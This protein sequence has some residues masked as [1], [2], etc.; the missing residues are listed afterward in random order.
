MRQGRR[1]FQTPAGAP[2]ACW[3]AL[4]GAA[5]LGGCVTTTTES[6]NTPVAESPTNAATFNVQLGANYLRQGDLQLAK[7]KIDKALEQDDS[8]P[9][10]N[11]YAGLLYDRLGDADKAAFHYHRAL[12]LA[13]EDSVTLNLYG[14]FL[15]RNGDIEKAEEY[16]LA[17]TRDP[18]YRTPEVPLTNAGVC[19]AREQQFSR[20]EAYFRRAL[21]N[22]A[23]YPDAL[24]Q[25]ARLSYDRGLMLQARAFFQRY[26][27]AEALTAEALWLGVRI[28][29]QLDDRASAE[30]YAQRLLDQYPD[31]REAR[32]L[33]EDRAQDR[34]RR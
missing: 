10:A 31:S 7:E 1:W 13:P 2:G 4:L 17:A 11:T 5:L 19:L 26:A 14:A 33:L 3:L 12:K 30:R 20:A 28:E 18:L 6:T 27:A 34:G 21:D 22:N 32:M 29:N 25:M 9:L 8:L 23:S 15:C 24:W 16:F